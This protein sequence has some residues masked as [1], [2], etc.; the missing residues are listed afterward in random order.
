M[1]VDASL[2]GKKVTN[3]LN[4]LKIIMLA[5]EEL[6]IAPDRLDVMADQGL[7]EK[8][9]TNANPM[10]EDVREVTQDQDLGIEHIV[11]EEVPDLV[12]TTQDLDLLLG[13]T[14][15]EDEEV[16]LLQ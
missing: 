11:K 15:T 7:Q 3:A 10:V 9:D 6:L 16:V 12:Q 8:I 5:Q 1:K 4:V 2:V 13:A 14:I